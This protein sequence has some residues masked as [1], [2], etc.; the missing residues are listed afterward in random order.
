MARQAFA[1]TGAAALALAACSG[2]QKTEDAAVNT[3]QEESQEAAS[4]MAQVA[5]EI[6]NAA[7]ANAVV[8]EASDLLNAGEAVENASVKTER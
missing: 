1:L 2:G 5:S 3:L 6:P 8:E 4:N 7:Q